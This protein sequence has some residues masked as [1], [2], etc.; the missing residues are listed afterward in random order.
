MGLGR[1]SSGQ[2]GL[3]LVEELVFFTA[4]C[5]PCSIVSGNLGDV[6]PV[7]VREPLIQVL[8]PTGVLTPGRLAPTAPQCT[9]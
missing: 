3:S 7:R 2:T 6:C 9:G 4:S 1:S 8:G 5:L